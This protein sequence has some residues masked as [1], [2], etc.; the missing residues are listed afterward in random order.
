MSNSLEPLTI[1]VFQPRVGE[2]FRIRVRPDNELEAELIEARALG[3]G[4][5]RA[6]SETPRRRTPFSLSFRT[7]LTAPLPQ[8]IYE[9]VHAEMGSYEIF[10]VPIG[11]DGRGMVYE[12]IFT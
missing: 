7:S 2:T 10:L 3:G 12:A 6:P 11:P 4:P 8:S 5:S 9:V 1:D